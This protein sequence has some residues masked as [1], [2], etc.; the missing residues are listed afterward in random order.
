MDE[1]VARAREPSRLFSADWNSHA[2]AL[3][4]Y[5][6][7][8][9]VYIPEFTEWRLE[10]DRCRSAL[11]VAQIFMGL[12]TY[13][14][15]MSEYPESLDILDEALMRARGAYVPARL[16]PLAPLAR[17]IGKSLPIDMFSGLP[18]EYYGRCERFL[19]QCH[20]PPVSD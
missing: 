13:Y 1:L 18:F 17:A 14:A 16:K 10:R 6:D 19:L 9:G 3:P 8:L 7:L 20:E 12:Q 2:Q 4:K 11:D 5:A 15:Y